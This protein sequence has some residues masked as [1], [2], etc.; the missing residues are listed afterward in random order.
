MEQ[1]AESEKLLSVEEGTEPARG[2]GWER[3]EKEGVSEGHS[4][5]GRVGGLVHLTL[6]ERKPQ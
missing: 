6:H 1:G 5:V 4:G 2:P 3:A